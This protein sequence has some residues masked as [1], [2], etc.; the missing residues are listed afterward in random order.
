M[1]NLTD[2]AITLLTASGEERRIEPSGHVARVE[3][4]RREVDDYGFDAMPEDVSVPIVEETPKEIVVR[5]R[6]KHEYDLCTALD[7]ALEQYPQLPD[8][9]LLLTTREVAEVAARKHECADGSLE[10]DWASRPG[11]VCSKKGKSHPLAAR[12]VWA[13]SPAYG[14]GESAYTTHPIGYREL[15]RV[16]GV[17]R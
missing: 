10:C 16:P 11:G 15:R 13:A 5:V 3:Y 14:V 6:D 7:H 4:E 8:D 9:P 17:A 1:L 2:T 12:M